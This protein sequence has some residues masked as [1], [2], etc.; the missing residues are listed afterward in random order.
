MTDIVDSHTRSRMMRGVTGKNTR[1]EVAV[2][3]RLHAAGLRFRLHA[4]SLP[5]RPDIVI[6]K[7]RAVVFVHG[8]FWH[9][10]QG[11][12]YFR[13]P[14]TNSDFW[15]QK[16]QANSERDARQVAEL[17]QLGWRVGLVWECAVRLD[18]DMAADRLKEFLAGEEDLV[19]ISG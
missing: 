11:C 4:A 2:R 7:H 1:P 6:R 10:H 13:V 8:C 17:L 18:A 15:R 19:E 3:Q 14:A 5:G 9:G 16:I 12:R